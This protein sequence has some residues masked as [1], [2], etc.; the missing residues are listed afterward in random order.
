VYYSADQGYI[1]LPPERQIGL[2]P[3]CNNKIKL[4]YGLTNASKQSSATTVAVIYYNFTIRVVHIGAERRLRY[5]MSLWAGNPIPIL[6][7]IS[8]LSRMICR[9]WC[10]TINFLFCT[11]FI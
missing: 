10:Y 9:C 6:L 1:R 2:L 8:V 4:S 5:L 11:N 7:V 3:I